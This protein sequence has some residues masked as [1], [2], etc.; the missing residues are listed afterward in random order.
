MGQTVL[1]RNVL[2]VKATIQQDTVLSSL[3]ESNIALCVELLI[4]V[5]AGRALTSI[6]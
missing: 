6:Q 4:S 3:L 5:G 1:Q 2:H